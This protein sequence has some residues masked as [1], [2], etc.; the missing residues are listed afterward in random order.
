[1]IRTAQQVVAALL[2][3]MVVGCGGGSD[4]ASPPAGPGGSPT[5]PAARDGYA[6]VVIPYYGLAVMSPSAPRMTTIEATGVAWITTLLEAD[7]D[8]TTGRAGNVAAR[9]AVYVKEGR[10]FRY[11]LANGGPPVQVSAGT[12]YCWLQEVDNKFDT[13][14]AGLFISTRGPNGVCEF[15]GDDP[16]VFASVDMPATTPYRPAHPGAPVYGRNG[17]RTGHV[18][19][20]NSEMFYAPADFTGPLRLIGLAGAYFNAIST[21]GS[22]YVYSSSGAMVFDAEIGQMTPLQPIS[23]GAFVLMGHDRDAAYLVERMLSGGYRLLKHE[24]R[25]RVSAAPAVSGT[26]NDLDSTYPVGY[27]ANSY[28]FVHRTL[29]HLVRVSPSG[30]A[31]TLPTRIANPFLTRLDRFG[32]QIMITDVSG[33]GAVVLVNPDSNGIQELCCLI[34]I[35]VASIAGD[36]SRSSDSRVDTRQQWADLALFSFQEGTFAMTSGGTLTRLS[37]TPF[38]LRYPN[39]FSYGSFA[40]ADRQ[41]MLSGGQREFEVITARPAVA[42]SLQWWRWR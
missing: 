11:D 32:R 8:P 26:W 18:V 13:Q 4:S 41:I 17:Q 25:G 29:G 31:T 23:G 19:I 9:H 6:R 14:R 40:H 12:D 27:A 20:R 35:Q 28:W 36:L 38:S 5:S 42:D 15:R 37:A 16:L 30:Q 34:N 22:T 39:A 24:L 10:L 21:P 2:V 3:A 7:I 1:M 33:S